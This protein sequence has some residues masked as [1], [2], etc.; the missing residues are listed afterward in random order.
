MIRVLAAQQSGEPRAVSLMTGRAIMVGHGSVEPLG[1]FHELFDVGDLAPFVALDL[2]VMALEA[3]LGSF[4]SEQ[5]W[6]IAVMGIMTRDTGPLRQQ[7][8]MLADRVLVLL[9][10]DAVAVQA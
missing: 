2:L 7:G 10:D 4:G 6:L 5:V 9:L 3:E 1:G 8:A